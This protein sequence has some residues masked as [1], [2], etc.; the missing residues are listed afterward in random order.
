[1]PDSGEQAGRAEEHVVIFRLGEE[2]YALDIQSIQE[3]V[4]M[5]AI[6]PIPG[7]EPWV[8]G[9][10]NLRGR[11]VPVIDLRVRCGMAPADHSAETRI[12]V[13]NAEGGMVGFI[14]DAVTEVMRIPAD[15][16]EPPAPFVSSA[17]RYVRGIAKLEDRLVSLMNLAGVLPGDDDLAL[18]DSETEAA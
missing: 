13:V 8:E 2:F 1:M 9:I 11:V 15:Q 6:T 5:Q 16:I 14:V 4:R 17:G 3:I 7:A 18:S 10:T 12:V